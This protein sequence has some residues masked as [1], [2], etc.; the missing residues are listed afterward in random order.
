MDTDLPTPH[1]LGRQLGLVGRAWSRE[2]VEMA[3]ILGSSTDS[4]GPR[5]AD[6]SLLA[7]PLGESRI[8]LLTKSLEL[9][10]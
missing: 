9:F 3:S 2:L 1:S 7:S 4:L 8:I 5:Q 6:L 10:C